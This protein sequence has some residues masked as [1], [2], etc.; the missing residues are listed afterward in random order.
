MPTTDCISPIE[1]QFQGRRTI[2]SGDGQRVSS[3][4]GV[5]LLRQM[6]ERL[7]ALEEHYANLKGVTKEIDE[8]REEVVIP[9]R[10]LALEP[11]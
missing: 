3:D 9:A 10:G 8:I 4:G 6:D 1:L 2:V 7:E 5:L 11:Q